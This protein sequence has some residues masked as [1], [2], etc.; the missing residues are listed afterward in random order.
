MKSVDLPN[1]L[2]AV[3][4]NA[5]PATS[6]LNGDIKVDAAIIG[7]G[8]TGLRAALVLAE[9]G[10]TVAVV[11]SGDIGWGASGR[12]GGQVNPIGHESPATIERRWHKDFGSEYAQRYV[13]MTIDSADEVFDLIKKHHIHCDAEQNGW[14]R[15]VHGDAAMP[16]FEDM[17]LGW[18]KSGADLRL[19]DQGEL[20]DR[21]GSSAYKHGW[22][23]SRGGS[24]QPLSYTRGL[25]RAA[26]SAGANIYTQT[27]INQLERINGSWQLKADE[28]TISADQVIL[29]TNGY[30]DQL[31]PGLR[32]SIVPVISI[33]AA[34][35]PLSEAQ[36]QQILQYRNTLA[37][38]RR[39]IHYYKKTADNR[40]VFGSAGTAGEL[41][42]LSERK[43][44][45]DGLKVVYPQFPDLELDYI[46]GGQIAVTQDHLPHIHQIA[47]G[48][49]AGLGCNGRGV[50]LST[51]MGRLM[52]E[53]VLGKSTTELPIP[54]TGI[55]S[56]PFHR[57]HRVGIKLAV[58][59]KEFF[60]QREAN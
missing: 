4:A 36:N 58:A 16:T 8:F 31:V 1:S 56:Y 18:Q 21:S 42:G 27:R 3:T 2:W 29:G 15:A 35:K 45:M 7:A 40:L 24:V 57:F 26:L 12:N 14:I 32:E 34:T 9:A 51:V 50:A 59:W 60:D 11:D 33:Q 39:V 47:P 41:P 48:L 23:A 52:A 43:R 46:W 25:G 38:T 28:G 37:D 53:T 22:L 44:I 54:V 10:S 5:G 20:E 13:Q 17:A 19:I 30:T 55:K 49:I 6:S